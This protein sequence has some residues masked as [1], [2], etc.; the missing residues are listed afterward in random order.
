L[1]AAAIFYESPTQGAVGN[2]DKQDAANYTAKRFGTTASTYL[3]KYTYDNDGEYLDTQYG[4]RKVDG[5]YMIGNSNVTIHDASDIQ[6]VPGGKDLTSG[7]CFL[8]Q[9][10]PI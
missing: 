5:V 2:I 1:T 3:V 6:G 8:G 9:T 10:I 4:I 7:E